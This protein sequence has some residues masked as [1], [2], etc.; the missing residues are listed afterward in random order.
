M[1]NAQGHF[2]AI[3]YALRQSKEGYV[4]SFVVHPDDVPDDLSKSKI[5]TRYMVAFAEIG[6]DDKPAPVAQMEE[7]RPSKPVVEGSSPSGRAKERKPFSSLPLSQQAA[8]RC[9]DKRFQEWLVS[10]TPGLSKCDTQGAATIVRDRCRVMSRS[11]LDANPKAA[12]RWK[13]MEESFSR[14]EVTMQYAEMVR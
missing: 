12:E 3:K 1:S 7:H 2:E 5:G 6:D 11:E 4:V 8:L 14:Y 10:I 13:L 9:Q